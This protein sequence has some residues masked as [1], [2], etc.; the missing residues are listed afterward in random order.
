MSTVSSTLDAR[1]FFYTLLLIA[2]TI[3]PACA[4]I[5]AESDMTPVATA[6]PIS[7]DTQIPEQDLI[8]TEQARAMVVQT[9]GALTRAAQPTFTPQPTQTSVL[10]HLPT[11]T[12]ILNS[13]FVQ[14]GAFFDV[15]PDVL[16]P[17]YEIENVCYFDT[18]SG[19]ERYEIYAGAIAGSGDEFSAQ[20]VAIVRIFQMQEQDGNPKVELV[21]TQEHLTFIKRGPLKLGMSSYCSPDWITLATPLNFVWFLHPPEEFFQYE[22][23][24]PLARL[25]SSDTRQIAE[26]GSYCW[27]VGCADGP[28]ISTSSNPLVIQS[29]STV[30]LYLPM[31]EAPDVL[32]LH[33]MFISPPDNLQFD[34]E[35]HGEKAEWSFEKEGRPLSKISELA[36]RQEQEIEPDLDPGYYVLVVLAAWQ[37]YGDVKYGFLIEVK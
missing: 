25:V 33:A 16:G 22:G 30:R 29:N 8:A 13:T 14:S 24:P 3:T 26:L 4:P 7:T 5:I 18:Q 10:A 34:H 32:E 28:G 31:E 19:W 12:P 27:D 9:E 15:P 2:L 35:V 1:H 20:G 21:D 6:K 17:R 36:L 23:T 37:E 11:L